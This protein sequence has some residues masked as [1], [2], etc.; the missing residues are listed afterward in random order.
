M[1][2]WTM[3]SHLRTVA[4]MHSCRETLINDTVVIIQAKCNEQ[5]IRTIGLQR[6]RFLLPLETQCM[7]RRIGIRP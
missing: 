2:G 5:N 6:L 7:Q 1:F 3:S 4:T